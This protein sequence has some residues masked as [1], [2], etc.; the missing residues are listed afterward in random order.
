MVEYQVTK[1]EPIKGSEIVARRLVYKLRFKANPE[2]VTLVLTDTV[3]QGLRGAFLAAT[4]K[5]PS[6]ETDGD[7]AFRKRLDET[8][9]S[10]FLDS[11]LPNDK[12]L[13]KRTLRSLSS[14]AQ[15]AF[16]GAVTRPS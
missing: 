6:D 8:E 5:L 2:D 11:L 14:E 7:L 3:I 4:D 9:F 13:L 10:K 16:L 1:V 12:G 15:E